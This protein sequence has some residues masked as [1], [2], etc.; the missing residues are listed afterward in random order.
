[1][2]CLWTKS[3]CVEI[4]RLVRSGVVV[5]VAAGNTGYGALAA[6][7]RTTN[8]GM[9]VTINDPGNAELASPS[10]PRIATCRMCMVFRIFPQRARLATDE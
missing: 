9:P 8:A 1:M 6:Q 4:N 2:V 7:Q 3:L 10:G 5:I